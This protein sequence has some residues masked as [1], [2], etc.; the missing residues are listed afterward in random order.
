MSMTFTRT[1]QSTE[2]ADG[3]FGAPTVTTIV[4]DG[5]LVTGEP[6]EYEAA[7]LTLKRGPPV[8]FT[9]NDYPLRAFTS[10]F[11]LPGAGMP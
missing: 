1:V 8:L 5:M 3:T 11:V 2:A 4:G 6:Q 7:G 10:E 9:P